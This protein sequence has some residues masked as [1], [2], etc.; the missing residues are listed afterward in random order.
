[1]QNSK[2]RVEFFAARQMYLFW[3][4]KIDE[5]GPTK[6]NLNGFYIAHGLMVEAVLK[7]PI[8]TGS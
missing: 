6:E 3:L 8:K 5:H 1:M 4:D 7:M 2:E